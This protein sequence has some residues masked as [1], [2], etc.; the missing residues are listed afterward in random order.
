MPLN[1]IAMS[2]IFFKRHN[3]TFLLILKSILKGTWICFIGKRS[4]KGTNRRSHRWITITYVEGLL[5]TGISISLSLFMLSEWNRMWIASLTLLAYQCG[6]RWMNLTWSMQNR[7]VAGL[8]DMVYVGKVS[9]QSLFW[10]VI[11]FLSW[12]GSVKSR[13]ERP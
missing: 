5:H 2:F 3:F 10:T 8:T 9:P 13:N 11:R 12:K 6:S 1:T 7:R 4:C